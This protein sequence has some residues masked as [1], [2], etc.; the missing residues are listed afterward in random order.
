MIYI[1]QPSDGDFLILSAIRKKCVFSHQ[2]KACYFRFC[3]SLMEEP[4]THVACFHDDSPPSTD[5][6]NLYKCLVSE[7]FLASW[8]KKSPSHS[9]FNCFSG[10]LIMKS[11]LKVKFFPAKG[12]ATKSQVKHTIGKR[13]LFPN[14]WH[15]H[16]PYALKRFHL[17]TGP[18]SDSVGTTCVTHSW[19]VLVKSLGKCSRCCLSISNGMVVQ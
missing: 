19:Y 10:H 8:A 11:V 2:L 5:K 12:K 16:L 18:K 15:V 17:L 9:G 14:I 1:R 6:F 4:D 13:I 3:H 7:P